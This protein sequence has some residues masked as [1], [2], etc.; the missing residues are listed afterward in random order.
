MQSINVLANMH[1][2]K[3]LKINEHLPVKKDQ[4]KYQKQKQKQQKNLT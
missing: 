4:K 1:L 3:T 2:Q